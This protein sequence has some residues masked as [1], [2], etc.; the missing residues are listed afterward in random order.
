[1]TAQPMK[2]NLIRG[3]T[4]Y[5]LTNQKVSRSQFKTKKNSRVKNVT[6]QRAGNKLN[7]NPPSALGGLRRPWRNAC[8]TGSEIE[9]AD[10]GELI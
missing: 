9:K 3:A 10:F 4:S 6:L 2:E 7:S 1:M 5:T 8:S